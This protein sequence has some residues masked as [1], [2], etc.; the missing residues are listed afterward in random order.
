[1]RN[2]EKLRDYFLGKD[3]QLKETMADNSL[4]LIGIEGKYFVLRTELLTRLKK[5]KDELTEVDEDL[6]RQIDGVI[7]DLEAEARARADK[8]AEID[9]SLDTAFQT[10]DEETFN[11]IAADR[12]LWDNFDNYYNK[13][14][15]NGLLGNKQDKLIAG[16]NITIAENVISAVDGIPQFE[17][18][19]DDPLTKFD[20][21]ENKIVQI[22]KYTSNS[23]GLYPSGTFE[24]NDLYL[25]HRYQGNI[26]LSGLRNF[27]DEAGSFHYTF[28]IYNGE[29]TDSVTP[30]QN[31]WDTIS[32]A[33]TN[34]QIPTAKAVYDYVSANGG[35]PKFNLAYNDATTLFN[36]YVGQVIQIESYKN[37]INQTVTTYN[38]LYYVVDAYT[39][40]SLRNHIYNEQTGTPYPCEVAYYQIEWSPVAQ[41]WVVGDTKLV[42]KSTSISS[43]STNNELAT[44]KAVYDFVVGNEGTFKEFDLAYNDSNT[45]FSDYVGKIVKINQYTNSSDQTTTEYTNLYIVKSSTTLLS[46]EALAYG[47]IPSV[48]QAVYTSSHWIMGYHPLLQETTSITS[49]S[50]DAKVPTAKAVYDFVTGNFIGNSV[51]ADI[52]HGTQAQYDAISPK[53]AT[54]LYLIDEE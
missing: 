50:T 22:T 24:C 20:A 51:I 38:D 43:S 49:T 31:I 44:A 2:I 7:A 25:V 9:N 45:K 10:I 12:N 48:M 8:D 29:W 4:R 40:Q 11:R 23:T 14:Q 35:L 47:N 36:D 3:P 18:R 6:Q 21:Y 52:W 5:L 30:D 17:L 19:Y 34:A 39:L 37:H 42:N 32:A 46:V 54:T 33:S 27:R 26:E 53:S 13:T 28:Y 41:M 1:M 15:T 16:T